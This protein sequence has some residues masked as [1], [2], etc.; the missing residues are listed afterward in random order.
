MQ[1][2]DI[3]II[4]AGFAGA[5]CA[6][7]LAAQGCHDVVVVEQAPSAGMA[8]SGRN[9]QMARQF[10]LDPAFHP[11]AVEGTHFLYAPPAEIAPHPL[12]RAVGSMI[13][14]DPARIADTERAVAAAHHTG[15]QATLIRGAEAMARV[16]VLQ[17]RDDERV[18]WTPTDGIVDSD[19]LL[20]G[21]L[22]AATQRGAQL[23]TNAPVRLIVETAEGFLLKAGEEALTA[24]VVVNAAGAW[25]GHVAGLAGLPNH[26]L[27]AYRRH[28]FITEPTPLIRP[29]WPFVWDDQHH[30]YFRPEGGGALMSPCDETEAAAD[31]DDAVDP[32]QRGAL[33]EKLAHRMP[34]LA[35]LPFARGWTGLRTFTPDRHFLLGW[36]AQFPRFYWI[37]GLGGHGVT[38]AAAVGRRAAEALLQGAGS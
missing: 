31:S 4:G 29:D 27:T 13:L 15:M 23:I 16:P 19:A 8:A 9:A 32:Y 1:H 24:R 34:A 12:I 14:L 6:Y 25:A 38:C 28:L 26:G 7:F 20:H 35:R 3:V 22:R 17:L 10:T 11:F 21:F 30:C 37:A 2:A 33:Q 36:D 18:V 5:A